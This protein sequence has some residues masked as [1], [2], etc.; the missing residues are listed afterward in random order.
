MVDYDTALENVRE[1]IQDIDDDLD[2]HLGRS[3]STNKISR[4]ERLAGISEATLNYM[5][6]EKKVPDS[7]DIIIEKLSGS[8][9]VSSG[10]LRNDTV[11]FFNKT[12][13]R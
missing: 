3:G 4:L 8:I 6:D 10:V 7:P 11:A 1:Y 12:G 2:R 9:S 13:L 5:V